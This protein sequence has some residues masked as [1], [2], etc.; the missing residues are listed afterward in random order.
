MGYVSIGNKLKD[1]LDTLTD[2]KAVYNYDPNELGIYPSATIEAL[3]HQNT[4][5]DTAA[6]NRT[7]TFVI[8]LF[9]RTDEDADAESILRDLADQVI[10]VL[11]QN[12]T[13]AGVWEILRQTN[14]QWI[15]A[16]REVPVR[17]CELTVE[18]RSRELR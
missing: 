16:Q 11:E 12:V 15:H 4:A 3:A 9:Y 6:N 14:A 18:I 2:L 8:R 10:D 7:Y 5:Y 17:V 1:L 13:V